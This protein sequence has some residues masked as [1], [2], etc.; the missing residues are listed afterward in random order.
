MVQP[1]NQPSFY[2]PFATN[3]AIRNIFQAGKAVLFLQNQGYLGY[4]NSEKY[5]SLCQALK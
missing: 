5:A 4:F 1:S 3:G 2:S